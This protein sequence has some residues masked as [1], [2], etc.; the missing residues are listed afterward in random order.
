[1][2]SMQ[3]TIPPE[4]WAELKPRSLIEQNARWVRA[5]SRCRMATGVRTFTSALKHLRARP[6]SKGYFTI[7]R[8]YGP[9]EAAIDKSWKPG[10]FE[11][12]K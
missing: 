7:V 10:D 12:V 5:I 6:A 4:F 2:S 9:T 1:V 8:L 11:K 3:A